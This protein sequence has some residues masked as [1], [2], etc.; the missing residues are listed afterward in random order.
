ME[1]RCSEEEKIKD[2]MCVCLCAD[3]PG[4]FCMK[5]GPWTGDRRKAH[6]G[7]GNN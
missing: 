7:S 2:K 1:G 6:G 4:D 3:G 5:G